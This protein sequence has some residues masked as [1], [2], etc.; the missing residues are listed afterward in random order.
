MKE[1][2]VKPELD[3]IELKASDIITDSECTEELPPF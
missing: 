2:Y 1:I 3:V